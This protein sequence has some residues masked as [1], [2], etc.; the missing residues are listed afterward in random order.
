MKLD[1]IQQKRIMQIFAIT[2]IAVLI[3]VFTNGKKVQDG[4][5]MNKKITIGEVYKTDDAYRGGIDLTYRYKVGNT[6]YTNKGDFTP[7]SSHYS[8]R[9]LNH[10]FP[11][12]YD[13]LKPENSAILVASKAFEI[14]Q[15]T[16]PDSLK[17]MASFEFLRN[18]NPPPYVNPY[19]KHLIHCPFL[20][21]FSIFLSRKNLLR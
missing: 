17:W 10:Y 13:S 9:I 18:P 11:V 6:E 15:I 8:N 20:Q 2:F 7:L 19:L 5:K 4:I 1:E 14:Y 3:I 21:I 12:V 16:I